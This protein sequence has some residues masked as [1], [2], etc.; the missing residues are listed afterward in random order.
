[1]YVNSIRREW[2]NWKFRFSPPS[3]WKMSSGHELKISMDLSRDG[4]FV[5]LSQPCSG[6]REDPSNFGPVQVWHIGIGIIFG[7]SR[8]LGTRLLFYFMIV[9]KVSQTGPLFRCA[10][11]YRISFFPSISLSGFSGLLHH[12]FEQNLMHFELRDAILLCCFIF[13]SI[14]IFRSTE[15]FDESRSFIFSRGQGFKFNLNS[16]NYF[17]KPAESFTFLILKY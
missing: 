16:S 17:L 6:Y 1:M 10:I 7:K 14:S 5:S 11:F 15:E 2:S 4:I 9:K 12:R 8:L 3:K 13:L